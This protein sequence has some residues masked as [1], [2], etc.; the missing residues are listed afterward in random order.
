MKKVAE[1]FGDGTRVQLGKEAR[2]VGG[3]PARVLLYA[4]CGVAWIAV[5][6]TGFAVLRAVRCVPDGAVKYYIL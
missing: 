4:W 2:R 1:G 5:R 6:A 3:Y